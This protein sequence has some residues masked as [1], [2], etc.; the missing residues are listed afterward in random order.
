M[1]AL[2]R[3]SIYTV[4]HL[5]NERFQLVDFAMS[6]DNLNEQ[7]KTNFNCFF[8]EYEAVNDDYPIALW[9]STGCH[10]NDRVEFVSKYI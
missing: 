3:E 4:W 8:Y 1:I 7:Y 5:R 2:D 10:F 6:V 9:G